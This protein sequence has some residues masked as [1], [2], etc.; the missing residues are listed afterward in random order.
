MEFLQFFVIFFTLRFKR[1]AADL[2]VFIS[3]YMKSSPNLHKN[4]I[5]VA[6]ELAP[7]VLMAKFP[8]GCR[9][10]KKFAELWK[11]VYAQHWQG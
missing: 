6:K 2:V 11:E 1:M 5:A 8:G 3:L 4:A 10:Y 9:S 7:G